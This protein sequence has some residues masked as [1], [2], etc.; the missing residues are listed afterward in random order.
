MPLFKKCRKQSDEL[1]EVK[2]K[3]ARLREDSE[4]LHTKL[5]HARLFV[6]KYRIKNYDNNNHQLFDN[7]ILLLYNNT[8]I[9]TF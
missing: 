4:I 7:I 3:L 8:I 5:K 9:K 2:L 6:A 1:V